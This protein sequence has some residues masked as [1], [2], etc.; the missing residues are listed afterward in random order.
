M[1]FGFSFVAV[2]AG[3]LLT[4][5]ALTGCGGSGGGA[6]EPPAPVNPPPVIIPPPAGGGFTTQMFGAIG[7]DDVD[8]D[9]EGEEITVWV[10]PDG[11]FRFMW[12]DYLNWEHGDALF[13]GTLTFDGNGFRGVGLAY[14]GSDTTWSDGSTVTT[15]AVTAEIIGYEGEWEW[16]KVAGTWTTVAGDHGRFELTE[17]HCRCSTD[18]ALQHLEGPWSG[19]ETG[20]WSDVSLTVNADGSFAG[21]GGDGCTL[22]GRFSPAD[23][24][25]GF[26]D[27]QLSVGGCSLAGD[28]VGL[29]ARDNWYDVFY[30]SADDGRYAVT[31]VLFR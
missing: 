11:R 10:A 19:H 22:G 14:A 28:Y 4:L 9:S 5:A 25:S 2:G 6:R 18:T 3:T 7:A 13:T 16:K 20:S 30:V 29:A 1:R 21:E 17:N 23:D 26:Y 24:Y 12:L 31:Y 15:V 8:L 27:L